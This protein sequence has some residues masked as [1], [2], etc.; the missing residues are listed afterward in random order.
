MS[1]IITK[2][3]RM[4]DELELFPWVDSIHPFFI[5]YVRGSRLEPPSLNYIND[6]HH[7]CRICLRVTYGT[8]FWKIGYIKQQNE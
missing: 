1:E 6:P 7:K 5:V 2:F 4:M 3:L 8:L